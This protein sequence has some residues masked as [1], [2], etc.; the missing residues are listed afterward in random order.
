MKRSA[1]RTKRPAKRTKNPGCQA[2]YVRVYLRARR[3]D[4]PSCF[5]FFLVLL[6]LYRCQ[7]EI[8]KWWFTAFLFPENSLQLSGLK[9]TV[10]T[11][12]FVVVVSWSPCRYLYTYWCQVTRDSCAIPARQQV[13]MSACNATK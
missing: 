8:S 4:L 13:S 5:A 1:K 6:K 12:D 3:E 11:L 9:K 2:V 7:V 10:S